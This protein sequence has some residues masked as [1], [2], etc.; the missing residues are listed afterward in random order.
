MLRSLKFSQIF[1]AEG[2]IYILTSLEYSM[3]VW[4]SQRRPTSDRKIEGS[5]PLL[6]AFLFA[7]KQSKCHPLLFF[8][9][10]QTKCREE[11]SFIGFQ[12]KSY[13]NL[14]TV[15]H[16]C[17]EQPNNSKRHFGFL[18]HQFCRDSIKLLRFRQIYDYIHVLFN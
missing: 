9:I 11:N 6:V 15:F 14:L 18:L 16:V 1:L 5:S 4:K 12:R 7:A 13:C 10:I 2:L 8:V 17:R 3:V